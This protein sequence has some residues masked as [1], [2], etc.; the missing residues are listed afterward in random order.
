MAVPSSLETDRWAIYQEPACGKHAQA[1]QVI[2]L[3]QRAMTSILFANFIFRLMGFIMFEFRNFILRYIRQY[4]N[5][6]RRNR[7]FR[8]YCKRRNVLRDNLKIMWF[9]CYREY[10]FEKYFCSS[11]IFDCCVRLS[12]KNF[13]IIK[14]IDIPFIRDITIWN[15]RLLVLFVPSWYIKYI[16]NHQFLVWYFKWWRLRRSTRSRWKF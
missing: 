3:L 2:K 12:W 15:Q 8:K 16:S 7:K 11:R 13:I 10:N 9:V 6:A 14:M 5:N 1:E 4:N